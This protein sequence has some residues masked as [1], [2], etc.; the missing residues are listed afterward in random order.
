MAVQEQ[1][2]Y[3]EFI[4]NGVTR[5]FHLEFDV[6]EQDHLIVLV[7][8]VEPSHGSWSLDV[9]ADT[10][11][12]ILPPV[13][14]AIIKI[15]RDTPMSRSTQYQSYNNSFRPASVDNDF[16]TIWRKMQE[17][18]VLNWLSNNNIKNLNEYVDSLNDETRSAFFA[19]IEKQGVSL[20]QLDNYVDQLY[21]KLANT[22]TEKEWLAE[23]I[24]YG[25]QTQKEFNDEINE[26]LLN[27]MIRSGQTLNL[28]SDF[29]ALPGLECTMAFRS[30]ILEALKTGKALC[31][32]G[33]PY[34]YF[35]RAQVL[36]FYLDEVPLSANKCLFIYGDGEASCLKLMDGEIKEKHSWWLRFEPKMSMKSFYFKS[37]KMDNNARGSAPP[38]EDDKYFH[39]QS[40]TISF[41]GGVGTTIDSITY[42]NMVVID[43][44][45]D[46][47]NNSYRGI[48]GTIRH[49]NTIERG[50]T[51]VR[52]SIQEG[53]GFKEI[54]ISNPLVH[55][56][57]AEAT[58]SPTGGSCFIQIN[59][60]TVN[61]LDTAAKSENDNIELEVNNLRVKEFSNLG[62][63]KK[64]RVNGGQ[65]RLNKENPRYPYLKDAKFSKVV[66]VLPYDSATGDLTQFA[67]LRRVD[68]FSKSLVECDECEFIIDHEGD[69]PI[70]VTK[71]LVTNEGGTAITTA[72]VGNH[73]LRITRSKFDKRAA[74]SVYAYRMGVVELKDNRYS[75]SDCA[76]DW[77]STSGHATD[78]T[79]DGGDFAT[80]SGTA[81]KLG[82]VSEGHKLT[83]KGEWSGSKA[84]TYKLLSGVISTYAP[85]IFNHRTILA[86]VLPNNALAGDVF[87]LGSA[88]V[89]SGT[90][91]EYQCTL[92]HLTAPSFVCYK[93]LG[94]YEATTALLPV[95]TTKEKLARAIDTTTNTFKTWSGSAWI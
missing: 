34:D 71:A 95:L 25:D 5:S 14:G 9:M 30:A 52:A 17:L 35:C 28:V 77:Y 70:P 50:R 41:A 24:A 38:P 94:I 64:L 86:N 63:L 39:E 93:Q 89:V 6:L 2:P 84:P 32:P 13:T 74:R 83:L 90:V 58:I 66:F 12:F 16:D 1:T 45:A 7:N 65:L 27:Q 57:E 21:K 85:A 69:L 26:K 15:Q 23:F 4:G 49:I 56:I 33:S 46:S 61:V 3:A 91:I 82:G 75:G 29:N 78:L 47:F 88:D 19:M 92:S 36:R 10:V 48:G 72:N 18:G 20:T 31:I 44:A 42:E 54:I 43:P 68:E 59:G 40:H 55:T 60:G 80:V 79:I 53:F 73:V 22:A 81:L 62:I 76:I 37:F 8:D 87:K 11:T 67:F 51:R